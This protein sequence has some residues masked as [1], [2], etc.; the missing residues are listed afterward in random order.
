MVV[1]FKRD[2]DPAHSNQ[3]TIKIPVDHSRSSN[4]VTLKLVQVKIKYAILLFHVFRS[5]LS[6]PDRTVI[7]YAGDIIDGINVDGVMFGSTGGTAHTFNVRSTSSMQEQITDI[8]F[9]H[10]THR[11]ALS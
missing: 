11:S 3:A 2:H 1:A 5:D 9:G 7:V 6:S 8:S 10:H 4:L